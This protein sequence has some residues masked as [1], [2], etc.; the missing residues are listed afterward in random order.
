MP[1]EDLTERNIKI[2]EAFKAK[3]PPAE[4]AK[5]YKLSYAH[6]YR[7]RDA[8]QRAL[9]KFQ[10]GWPATSPG[11]PMQPSPA[12]QL[13]L[14]KDIFRQFALTG[15]RR[16]G[17]RVDD[18]YDRNF[19][20][21]YRRMQTFREMGDD[22]IVASVIQAIKMV[23]RRVSWRSDPAGE[24][25][26]DKRGTEWLETAREDMSQ[27]WG[28]TIDQALGMV[29]YGFQLG[30]L[31]YKRRQGPQ[32][33]TGEPNEKS[34]SKYDDGKIGWRK[35]TFIAPES[36]MPGNEWNFDETGGIQGFNQ[37]A[38]P[39]YRAVYVPIQKAV[40][41]RTTTEKN[42]P[43]GR[44]ILRAM[45]RPY[46]YKSN[47]EEV[48]GISAERMGAGFPVIY[49]GSDTAKNVNDPTSDAA[50]FQNIVRN[51]RIDEQMGL[52]VPYA[53][54]GEG[55]EPGKGVLVELMSPP[56]RG[57]V[58]F[59]QTI[60]RYAK[61][62]ALVG[63]AQFTM[64][65]MSKIGTQALAETQS[66]FFTMAIDAWA[67]GIRD[68]INRYAVERLFMLNDFPGLSAY[69]TIEHEPIG[70]I[71]LGEMANY[72]NKLVGVAVLTPG[73]ELEAYMREIAKLPEKPESTQP[74]VLEGE[75]QPGTE[76]PEVDNAPGEEGTGAPNMTEAVKTAKSG[77]PPAPN[78][79]T[80]PPMKAS[81]SAAP[82]LFSELIDELRAARRVLEDE[83]RQ[84]Q[85]PMQLVLHNANLPEKF[86]D[87]GTPQITVNVPEQKAP[88]V[89]V[90]VPAPIV[91]ITAPEMP[92][93]VINLHP[94]IDNKPPIVNVSQP[95]PIINLPREVSEEQ[96]VVRDPN[97]GHILRTITRKKYQGEA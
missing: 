48:E 97:T 84:T 80:K 87:F 57:N 9:E 43:E 47:L 59:N 16:F 92:T 42:N 20:S 94:V 21:L 82:E 4:I 8:G 67:D 38:P 55:A 31:V 2:A 25:D 18:E 30:E 22:A 6:T 77:A 12:R 54:M 61:Q 91:N 74:I 86:M 95:A 1:R 3:M 69:P 63:L 27:T 32:P 15:L 70:M 88:I 71:S 51:I 90:S 49:M 73:P 39:W 23:I 83:P 29:Q 46:F 7:A 81:A 50:S 41:F 37:L 76:T 56:S 68:T 5:Q 75:T 33:E 11:A 36:L 66:D 53:K 40:L 65:G 78:E 28:D 89:N 52:L 93:P 72:V 58:D 26:A 79:V 45:W 24:T 14:D 35:W 17:G 62:I 64:L 85:A 13:N 34:S 60:D 10:A 96:E 44:S 19:K